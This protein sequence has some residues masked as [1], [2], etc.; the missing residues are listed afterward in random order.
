ME[1]ENQAQINKVVIRN[2]RGQLQK[3]TQGINHFGRPK[4]GLAHAERWRKFLQGVDKTH[5][6][7]RE[8]VQ[9]QL[10]YEISTDKD[11][12]SCLEA[13][14]FCQVKAYGETPKEVG[15]SVLAAILLQSLPDEHKAFIAQLA[16]SDDKTIL[17]E[18]VIEDDES[19]DTE[20][21]VNEE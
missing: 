1:A 16:F 4:L 13:I 19:E 6:K 17:P 2:N 21:E 12:K 7:K 15:Q 5:G 8:Q 11:N 9:M 18:F 20:Q 3:G 14:K 10:A